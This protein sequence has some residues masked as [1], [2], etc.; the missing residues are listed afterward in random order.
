MSRWRRSVDELA[1]RRR[2]QTEC[3]RAQEALSRVTSCFQQLAVSLGSSADCSF[4]R[5]EMD[6]TRALAHRISTGTQTCTCL[7]RLS[8]RLPVWLSPDLSVF[9][10]AG[11]SRRLVRL[12]SDCDSAPSGVEDRQASERLWVLFLSA[13]ESFLSDLRKA[14]ILIGQFPL[15][16]RY[17]RRSLVN[18][19]QLMA[20]TSC[21]WKLCN[22]LSYVTLWIPTHSFSILVSLPSYL[23][24]FLY[25]LPTEL[26]PDCLAAENEPWNRFKDPEKLKESWSFLRDP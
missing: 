16:Q 10:S 21:L 3:E 8:P 1:A 4:L 23:T 17:D 19:G 20:S 12:L 9:L 15:T 7:S 13:L 26:L 11:L 14:C 6:E 22:W 18:S 24:S 2:Q 25:F 5:D